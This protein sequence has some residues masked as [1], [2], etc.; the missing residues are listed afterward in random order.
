MTRLTFTL[1]SLL[2]IA[3]LVAGA[4]FFSREAMI[5]IAMRD[6]ETEPIQKAVLSWR[7]HAFAAATVFC[8]LPLVPMICYA[9]SLMRR[10]LS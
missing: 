1:L 6:M 7:V 5:A 3:L 2:T 4:F 10:R 8:I 9:L